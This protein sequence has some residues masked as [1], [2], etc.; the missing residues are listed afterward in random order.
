MISS[1]SNHEAPGIKRGYDRS[2]D[3][4]VL[5]GDVEFR[6]AIKQRHEPKNRCKW[7][8]EE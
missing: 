2:N 4:E 7:N 6:E 5:P 1:T 3:C 8:Y